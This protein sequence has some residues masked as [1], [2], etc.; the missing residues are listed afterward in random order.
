MGITS[1]LRD[2]FLN[3]FASRIN[4]IMNRIFLASVLI[5]VSAIA[6]SDSDYV[7]FIRQIQQ[8]SGLEWDVTVL[9]TGDGLISTT[10]VS[11]D[12]SFFELWSIHSTSSM[13]NL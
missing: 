11:S 1:P 8:D 3:L 7:N 13:S 5:P 2:N 12:G 4:I 9:P 6:D 10:G